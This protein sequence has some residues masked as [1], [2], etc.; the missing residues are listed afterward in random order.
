[1]DVYAEDAIRTVTKWL[2][3]VAE[4]GN[5]LEARVNMSYAANILCGYTQALIN[6]TSH[7]ITAQTMGGLFPTLPHGASLILIAEAYYANVKDFFPDVFDKMGEFMGE[8]PVAGKPGQAFVN[9]LT[10]LM[11]ATRMRYLPM[12]EFGITPDDIE[13]IAEITVNVVGIDCDRYTLTKEDIT[14]ILKNSYK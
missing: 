6:T 7:H 10:K 13:K 11:D 8:T 5:D 14:Q 2:P 3:A 9:G 12:S 1:V 4:N